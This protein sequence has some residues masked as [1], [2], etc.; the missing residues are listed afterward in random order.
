MN[1]ALL[2][3]MLAAIPVGWALAEE[4][5]TRTAEPV[6]ADPVTAPASGAQQQEVQA[7][8]QEVARLR[9]EMAQLKAKE[10]ALPPQPAPEMR[11]EPAPPPAP[12]PTPVAVQV[13][14]QPVAEAS[15]LPPRTFVGVS[16]VSIASTT[17]DH[18]PALKVVAY[19]TIRG[20]P[21]VPFTFE[22][23]LVTADEKV[24]T[25]IRGV[26]YAAT[27]EVSTG[28][29]EDTD[30]YGVVVSLKDLFSSNPP[31]DLF[32]QVRILDGQGRIIAKSGLHTFARPWK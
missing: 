29:E 8:Q 21:N 28:D 27:R 9:D 25:S 4:P 13:I 16:R 18:A 26:P 2:A 32:V 1:R 31:A 19:V 22:G 15:P 10:S 30:N 5:A 14:A 7:L 17:S 24:H 20:L 3:V 6:K 12:I 11:A 23:A